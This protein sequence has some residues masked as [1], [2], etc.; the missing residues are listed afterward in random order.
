MHYQCSS[1][2]CDFPRKEVQVDHIVEAG[3]LRSFD[4]LPGFVERLFVEQ[5]GLTVLCLG[6]HNIKTHNKK[7]Q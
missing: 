1:C 3:S 7:E 6:C 5:E 4:D 2:L